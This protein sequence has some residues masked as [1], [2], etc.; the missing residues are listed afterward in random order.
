MEE[1]P[2][3][4]LEPLLARRA[5]RGD[6]DAWQALYDLHFAGLH[7]HVHWRARGRSELVEEALQE[8]WLVAVRRLGDFDPERGAFGAWLRGIADHALLGLL[9]KRKHLGL[10]PGVAEIEVD[11]RQVSSRNDEDL[12]AELRAVFAALPAVY[13]DVLLAA[14]REQEKLRAAVTYYE[15]VLSTINTRIQVGQA[16]RDAGLA[17]ERS[18]LEA[19]AG[20]SQA[21]VRLQYLAGRSGP[22]TPQGDVGYV[23]GFAPG[24]RLARRPP[25]PPEM[26]ERLSKEVKLDSSFSLD[27]DRFVEQLTP[28][29]PGIDIVVDSDARIT[30]KQAIFE[31]QMPLRQ[32][33]LRAAD[34]LGVCFVFRE[35][36]IL[37]TTPQRAASM[38]SATIPEDAAREQALPRR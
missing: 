38:L 32:Q 5:C 31:R 14:Q 34:L 1:A 35:Y 29:F 18:L 33:L 15:K 16:E 21:D 4:P 24:V 3:T 10:S 6:T 37:V 13:T 8:A 17:T 20:A 22:G 25:I 11:T 28:Y 23:D 27:I 19:K 26:E 2:E 9:R 30:K 7:A 36:G 12:G